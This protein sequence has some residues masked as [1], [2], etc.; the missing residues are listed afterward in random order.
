MTDLVP[1][2]HGTGRI[3]LAPDSFEDAWK[4]AGH[5]AV[6]SFVPKGL[7]GDRAAVFAAIVWASEVGVGV[8]QALN[9]VHVIEGSVSVKPEMMRALIRRA[10]HGLE[11]VE[12]TPE[13]CVI[14]GERADTGEK[15]TGSFTIKEAQVAGLTGKAVWKQYPADMLLARATSRLGRSLFS[16][17]IAGI[18]YTPD[19]VMGGGSMDDDAVEAIRDR[20]DLVPPA[21]VDAESGEI[22]DAEVVELAP[23]IPGLD[24]RDMKRLFAVLHDAGVPE[25]ARHAFVSEVLEREVTSFKELAVADV[26]II[27][28][29]CERRRVARESHPA[30]EVEVEATV[31]PFPVA[32]EF[33]SKD[34]ADEAWR[35]RL[36]GL[37]VSHKAAWMAWCRASRCG[38]NVDKLTPE[39]IREAVL[40]LGGES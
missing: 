6:T 10:G 39:Q 27:V 29:A 31:I 33:P 9:G 17:V 20:T 16:D 7:R 30:Q 40:H 23:P 13:R 2:A 35:E 21:N 22:I 37:A 24:Q 1:V 19:E 8:I 38:N 25:D 34:E 28:E 32:E 12:S 36:R 5:L 11:V 26:P 3:T 14:V 4:V 18:S 15:G